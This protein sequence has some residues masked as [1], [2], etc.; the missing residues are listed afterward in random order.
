MSGLKRSFLRLAVA[1]TGRSGSG[2]TTFVAKLAKELIAQGFKVVLV[3]HD[4][5]DKAV[6][7]TKGK[8]SFIYS[9]LGADVAVVSPIR[10]SI[11]LQS[12][13]FGGFERDKM[14]HKNEDFHEICAKT[15]AQMSEDLATLVAHFGEFDFMFV[16]GLKFLPLPRICIVRGELDAQYLEFAN[17]VVSDIAVEFSGEKFGFEQ[18]QSVLEWVKQNGAKL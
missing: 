1:F 8:D 9:S 6:F 18:T 16:E 2:K 15:P 5:A 14:R 4:P 17:A 3:K 11:F 7:D 12:G 10:T 13:L